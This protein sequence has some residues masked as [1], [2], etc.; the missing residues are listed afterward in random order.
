MRSSK[1]LRR[2]SRRSPYAT[3]VTASTPVAAFRRRRWY[4]SVSSGTRRWLSRLVH[5]SVVFS[6]AL[7]P[8]VPD[9]LQWRERVVPAA[10]VRIRA[11]GDA[12]R[13]ADF[14]SAAVLPS[15]DST[16]VTHVFADFSGTMTASDSS[17]TDATDFGCSPSRN[18]PASTTDARASPR[19]PGS[20]AK[21][22]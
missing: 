18:C 15:I 22:I 7:V 9:P 1:S 6:F 4:A 12:F 14:L 8:I 2:S 17:A 20:R 13:A 5:C 3:Q 19:S 21:G 10:Q 11:V 16:G